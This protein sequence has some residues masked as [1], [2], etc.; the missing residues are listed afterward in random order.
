METMSIALPEALKLFVRDRVSAGGYRSVSEYLGELIRED[1]R[2]VVERVDGSLQE[3]LE[4]GEPIEVGPGYWEA[5]KRELA[6]K[7]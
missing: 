5:K 6:G 1:Q 7:V 3:A 4:S 2:L